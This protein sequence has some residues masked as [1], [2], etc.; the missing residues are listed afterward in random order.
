MRSR[1]TVPPAGPRVAGRS[2]LPCPRQDGATPRPSAS[3]PSARTSTR[4]KRKNKPETKQQVCLVFGSG[5]HE[6]EGHEPI[7]CHQPES[8]L[9][10]RGRLHDQPLRRDDDHDG[11]AD[12]DNDN[13]ATPLYGAASG[14]LRA[15]AS[16]VAVRPSAPTTS[17]PVPR[18]QSA[19]N[20]PASLARQA[21]T[22][23]ASLRAARRAPTAVVRMSA[24]KVTADPAPT[25]ATVATH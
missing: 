15:L 7:E 20:R 16:V 11:G 25:T 10:L 8:A 24:V 4:N 5:L 17:A 1:L 18:Q 9:Q 23:A 12:N 22:V 19:V 14:L 6:P 3:T 2:W 21:A 13:D